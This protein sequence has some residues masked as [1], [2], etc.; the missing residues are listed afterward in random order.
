MRGR[1]TY[2]NVALLCGSAAL[3]ESISSPLSHCYLFKSCFLAQILDRQECKSLKHKHLVLTQSHKAT[4]SGRHF[5]ISILRVL[6]PLCEYTLGLRPEAALGGSRVSRLKS[7]DPCLRRGHR[8]QLV[9]REGAK[10]AKVQI[11]YH[12]VLLCVLCALARE[13]LHFAQ[14]L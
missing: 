1:T 5:R 9:S 10:I 6:V 11:H 12:S 4:E 2:F 3:C 13:D 14:F 8:R 7:L